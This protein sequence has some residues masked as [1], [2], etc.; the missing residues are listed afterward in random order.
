MLKRFLDFVNEN[1]ETGIFDY[2]GMTFKL[3]VKFVNGLTNVRI[4]YM[5]KH[6]YDLS[7]NIPG[8]DELDSDEFYL[9]PDIDNDLVKVL[10]DQGFLEETSHESMAGDKKTNSYKL[11]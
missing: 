6:Y 7:I 1:Y 9:N 2:G 3:D 5:D 4:M 11:V 10:V 8:S